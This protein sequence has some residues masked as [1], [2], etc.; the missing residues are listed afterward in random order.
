MNEAADVT[1]DEARQRRLEIV[2][3]LMAL[4]VVVKDPETTYVDQD[5]EVGAETVLYP[6]VILE[7]GSVVGCGCTIHARARITSSRV[8]DG[9]TI[10]DGSILEDSDV[11]AGAMIGPYARL[12]PG[13]QIGAG[14]KVGNFVETKATRM[15]AGSKASHLTYLGDANVGSNVNIGAGTITCNYDGKDKHRTIIE[16]GAF[17][18]SNV[19]L[20]APVRI[21]AG[22][23]V[24]A[25]ST[26]SGDVPAG[27]L[28]LGRGEQVIK[29]GWVARRRAAEKEAEEE[30]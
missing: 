3:K 18:G 22:A 11:D 23:Y 21:G 9:V 15:G 5:V 16:D 20:V 12:R 10:L 7:A 6:G 4:G 26:V 27:A 14:A 13:S 8:G 30:A 1:H 25:G 19:S 2:R 17:V 24:G 28:A 29:H